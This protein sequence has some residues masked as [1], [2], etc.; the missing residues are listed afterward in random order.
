MH[1]TRSKLSAIDIV[2]Y[3]LDNT[4]DLLCY[5]AVQLVI[6]ELEEIGVE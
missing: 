6:N 1:T 2:G 4:D 3:L 5:I